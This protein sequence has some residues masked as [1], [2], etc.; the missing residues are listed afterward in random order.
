MNHREC[1]MKS[2]EV[3]PRTDCF[4]VLSPTIG[5]HR[6]NKHQYMNINKITVKLNVKNSGKKMF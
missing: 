3:S 4:T 5:T 1:E 6:T 2:G